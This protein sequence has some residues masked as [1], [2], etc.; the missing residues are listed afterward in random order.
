MENVRKRSQALIFGH[1]RPIDSA[2]RRVYTGAMMRH[3]L[4]NC[5]LILVLLMAAE[6]NSA[7]AKPEVWLQ[8]RSPDFIVLTNASEKEGRRVAYQFETIR[9][10]FRQFFRLPESA[11]DPPVIILALKDEN[12]L[13]P[14][15]PEY[16]EKKGL[17]HPAGVY[18]GGPEKNYV[19]LRLDV[20]MKNEAEEPFEPVYHE[21]VHFLTRRTISQTPLWIVEGLAEFYGNTRIEGDKVFVGAPSATNLRTLHETPPIPLASLFAVDASSPYYHEENKASIFY[22]QSWALTHF[23]ITRDWR[24]QTHRFGDFIKLLGQG[25]K[26]EEAA[27]KTIGDPARLR[28]ELSQYIDRFSFTVARVKAPPKVDPKDF[29]VEPSSDAESLTM[30]ADFMAHDRHFQEAQGM[31]E[32]VLRRGPPLAAAYESMGFIL[33]QQGKMEEATKWYGQAVGLNSQS[34]LAN[35]YYAANLAKGRPDDNSAAKAESCLRAAIKIAPDFAPAYSMLAWLMAS[36]HENLEEAH[37]LALTATTLEPGSVSYRLNTATVLEFMGR[38]DDAARVAKA[39]SD[40]AKTLEEKSEALTVL[41]NVQQFQEYQKRAK[42]QEEAFRKAQS[43]AAAAQAS[44]ANPSGQSGV[45]DS[46][47]RASGQDADAVG[48]ARLSRRDEAAPASTGPPT[49]RHR[50]GESSADSRMLSPDSTINDHAPRPEVLPIRKSAEGIIEDAKCSGAATLE[51][52]IHSAAGVTQLYSDNYFKVTF[53]ALNF[54]PHGILNPCTDIKG[55]H[56]RVT[57]HPTKGRP[58]QGEIVAVGLAKD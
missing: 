3:P 33:S 9:A 14:L 50:D 46:S 27:G 54:I 23:L 20:S 29:Q 19:A 42:E 18:L 35:Y 26:A 36:R 38:G 4:R 17:M 39:A 1:Q 57:F 24:E 5:L 21:Y 49:L 52:G 55:W 22:A 7:A 58:M 6:R 37:M 41:A 53:S 15:L 56:A 47:V 8:V 31:L 30:R 44:Q 43:E 34:Y 40:M 16:W 13:K 51:I 12:S 25:V 32:E 2:S 11:K 28:D 10:V 45:D 48:P